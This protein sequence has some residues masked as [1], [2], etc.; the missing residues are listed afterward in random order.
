MTQMKVVSY[1]LPEKQIKAVN[2]QAKRDEI[3]RSEVVRRALD[4]YFKRTVR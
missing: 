3:S 2:A 4:A 1:S